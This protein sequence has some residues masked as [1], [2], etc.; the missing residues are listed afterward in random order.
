MDTILKALGE[1]APVEWATRS[2]Q[3]LLKTVIP[4]VV[5]IVI[6]I[7]LVI[8]LPQWATAAALESAQ[9]EIDSA[10]AVFDTAKS[11]SSAE[12]PWYRDGQGYVDGLGGFLETAQTELAT[13][14]TRFT[15]AQAARDPDEKIR[16]ANEAADHAKASS[17][18]SS[19]ITIKL[20]E[21]N[22]LRTSVRS[23][24]SNRQSDL[25]DAE[26]K[27]AVVNERFGREAG[28]HLRKY[29]DPL[30]TGLT[31]AQTYALEAMTAI[32]TAAEFLPPDTDQRGMGDPLAARQQLDRAKELID[33]INGLMVTVTSRLNYLVEAKANAASTTDRANNDYGS[34]K[35]YVD[36]IAQRYG[37]WLR[38][39]YGLLEE[40]L[41]L[42]T[43]AQIALATPVEETKVDLPI[44]YDNARN[45]IDRS[46]E[47]VRS[48]DTEVATAQAARDAIGRIRSR[49]NDVNAVIDR[50]AVANT[51]LVLYHAQ[52]TWSTISGNIDRA[53]ESVYIAQEKASAAELL[54]A[55]DVQR[56]A[57]GK[58]TADGG[59]A[60]LDSAQMFAQ[61][62][63]DRAATLE[64]YRSQW[65]GADSSAQ[66]A[67]NGSSGDISTFG[68][69][70][71]GATNDFHEAERLL[72]SARSDASA[73]YFEDAVAKAN[74][75]YN[76]ADDAG[77]RA[78]ASYDAEIRRQEEEARRQREEEARRQREEEERQR[79][80]AEEAANDLLDDGGSSSIGSDDGG[81]FS[82]SGGDDGG[83]IDT[84][85]D[86][87]GGW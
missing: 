11:R 42:L 46:A 5:L 1:L 7:I 12:K 50:A 49:V 21:I 40:A 86:D 29:T 66:S 83:G 2:R 76:L 51:A 73:G 23:E 62:V 63:V 10:Q 33:Q 24:L 54:I 20:D 59:L 71:S 35:G 87:G 27:F 55:L 18:N 41:R 85:G 81:S 56:F 9:T 37:Y 53:R 43:S 16:L 44:A 72:S 80:E 13:A 69:Y 14:W 47:A 36:T 78:R 8:G 52:P 30:A 65:P 17:G 32:T 77:S 25:T 3:N 34:S 57:D 61:A 26:R 4:T 58:A 48:A 67:I 22:A 75:A 19:S 28:D 74:R 60:D 84:G 38:A 79:R 70:D 45:S 31:Q 15:E 82:Y 6:G 64:S 68:G 39:A